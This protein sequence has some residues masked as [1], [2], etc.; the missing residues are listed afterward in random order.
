MNKIT[1]Y[2]NGSAGNHGCEAITRSLI[3]ILE[4]PAQA[5]YIF[6]SFNVEEDKKY[7]EDCHVKFCKISSEMNKYS[8]K[9]LIYRLKQFY[10]AS[11]IN[12][13]KLIYKEFLNNI[14]KGTSYYSIGGDNYSYGFSEWLYYLNQ[15]INKKG[16]ETSLIGCSILDKISNIDLRNDLMLYKK[17]VCRESLTYQALKNIG[18]KNIYLIPDPAFVLNRIDLPLPIGFTENNTI[19]INIS[20]M[21]IG[22]ENQNG[23]IL[24]NYLTLIQYIINQTDMQI[25]LIPHVIWTHCDDRIPLQILFNKFKNTGRICMIKDHNAEELKGYIARCRFMIAARTHA[26]IAA[27]S[28]KIPTLVIG[29]SVKAKGIATDIFGTDKNYVIP[30]QNLN[31]PNDLKDAFIQLMAKEKE[32]KNY[33]NSFI[34][35]YNE[36]CLQL[37]EIIS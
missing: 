21:I 12:Y 13:Y 3:K 10:S 36:R 37:K 31:N 7:L 9:Y 28:E 29:Y 23:M 6:A 14:E 1:F 32:I 25:A 17:I 22:H 4:L 20:P 2:A 24:Q 33:M 11:D 8:L 18:I 26:S 19:G 16:A 27:Y 30:A 35:E 5:K 15:E 34:P